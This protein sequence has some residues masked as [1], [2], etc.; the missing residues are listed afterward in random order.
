MID[1]Y[2]YEIDKLVQKNCVQGIYEYKRHVEVLSTGETKTRVKKIL[3][4]H[5]IVSLK[6]RW[7]AT[8]STNAKKALVAKILCCLTKIISPSLMF[9]SIMLLPTTR[10]A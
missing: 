9:S 10:K 3:S 8:R 7:L 5:S 4:G 2:K 6:K 1:L